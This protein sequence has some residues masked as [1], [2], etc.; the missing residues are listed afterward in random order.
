[1]LKGAPRSRPASATGAGA[2][3]V[4]ALLALARASF[5]RLQAAWDVADEQT[6]ARITTEPLMADLRRQLRE[7]PPGPHHTE[8]L[9]VEAQLLGLDELREAFVASVEFTGLI[10]EQRGA[11]ATRFREMWL[12]ASAKGDG[13]PSLAGLARNTDGWRLAAVQA[14]S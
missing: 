13:D 2:D 9:S 7:R 6:L 10:R 11:E 5:V 12:L 1:M 4:Q 3:G 8:V 14:L